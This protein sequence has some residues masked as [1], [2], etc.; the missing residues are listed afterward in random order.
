MKLL[1]R[2]H[3]SILA[4]IPLAATILV[5]AQ[6]PAQVRQLPTAYGKLPLSFEPNQGQAGPS[7]QFLSHGQSYTLLLSHGE[8]TLA[9]QSS[10]AVAPKLCLINIKLTGSN[11]HASNAGEA[12]LITR[13]NYFLGSDTAKWHTDIPT[14]AA[15]VI[16]LFTMESTWSTTATSASSN[17]T[18]SSLPT[19]TPPK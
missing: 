19:P 1:A 11:P 5:L 16:A 17:T 3:I 6:T 9:L 2:P 18:S 4:A 15:S 14:M 10:G 7:V 13:S 8:A 12:R